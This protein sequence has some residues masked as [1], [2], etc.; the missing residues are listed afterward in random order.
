MRTHTH[1]QPAVT[2]VFARPQRQMFSTPNRG[3]CCCCSFVLGV[4][5]A[6][7]S[8]HP[9]MAFGEVAIVH[10]SFVLLKRGLVV[11]VGSCLIRRPLSFSLS[12]AQEQHSCTVF[13]TT[14]LL[15]RLL[16]SRCGKHMFRGSEQTLSSHQEQHQ[17]FDNRWC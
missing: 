9:R 10:L 5:A 8:R 6:A 13:T 15:P 16:A 14:R 12:L 11:E 4:A 7:T 17:P 1:T 3:C 2:I